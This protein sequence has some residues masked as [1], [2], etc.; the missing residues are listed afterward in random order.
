MEE[1]KITGNGIKSEHRAWTGQGSSFVSWIGGL[2]SQKGPGAWTDVTGVHSTPRQTLSPQP[3]SLLNIP[4][5]RQKKI[6]NL[7]QLP[8]FLLPPLRRSE[9]QCSCRS[10]PN[11]KEHKTFSS[12]GVYAR[13]NNRKII[14]I[15]FKK[16]QSFLLRK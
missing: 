8:A 11:S 2:G 15:K 4:S 10:I 5:K 16:P 14:K 1:K 9:A 6:P 3:V 7:Q 13:E 12:C